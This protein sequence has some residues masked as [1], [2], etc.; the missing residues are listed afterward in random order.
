MLDPSVS[1]TRIFPLTLIQLRDIVTQGYPPLIDEPVTG[2]GNEDLW[3]Q[4]CGEPGEE[5]CP[6][7]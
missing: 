5:A 7:Q 1:V 4:R 2:A 3:E 6:A